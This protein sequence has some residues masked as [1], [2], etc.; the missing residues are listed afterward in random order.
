M[1]RFDGVGGQVWQRRKANPWPGGAPARRAPAGMPDTFTLPSLALA[2]VPLLLLLLGLLAMLL[3]DAALRGL[4]GARDPV[5]VAMLPLS[6]GLALLGL[7]LLALN[8]AD[9]V[10]AQQ[11]WQWQP[12]PARVVH[13][14]LVQTLQPRAASPGWRPDVRYAYRHGAQDYTG[15]RVAFHSLTSSDRAATAAWLQRSYPAGAQVTAYVNPADPAQ[16]V[17]ERGG[18]VWAW[19]MAAVGLVLAGS[20]LWL[21]RAALRTDGTGGTAPPARRRKRRR[22][23]RPG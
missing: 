13:S 21:L 4:A 11:A 8:A 20:G 1:G 2:A 6:V 7:L 9:G 15:Q 19:W 10:R 18:A 3:P 5:A 16:S 22:R 23:R 14:G 12:V 17:L